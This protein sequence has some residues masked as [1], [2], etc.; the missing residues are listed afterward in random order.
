M[1]LAAALA[2]ALLLWLAPWY[3]AAPADASGSQAALGNAPD[4]AATEPERSP[5]AQS[6]NA[7]VSP[8][9]AATSATSATPKPSSE[10]QFHWTPEAFILLPVDQRQYTPTSAA[11]AK[12][13]QLHA[14]PTPESLARSDED[15]LRD[16]AERCNRLSANT[17]IERLRQRGDGE[18]RSLAESAAGR[19]SL[20]AARALMRDEVA[21]GIG[22]R[23]PDLIVRMLTI[24][25]NLGGRG[26]V[27]NLT[28]SSLPRE[29]R[30]IDWLRAVGTMESTIYHFELLESR[31]R[32]FK[33]SGQGYNPW[34]AIVRAA[35]PPPPWSLGIEEFL[36]RHP[37]YPR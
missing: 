4:A 35:E 33:P 28:Q 1:L 37:E 8:P 24:A 7:P 29:F 31:A 25:M 21:K 2:I 15:K 22:K 10:T 26:L 23:D 32:N 30:D 18:W 11:Q 13:M 6:A 9:R 36:K 14:F 16:E 19:G 34:C 27:G 17:L 12:W 3:R 5:Q 20:F